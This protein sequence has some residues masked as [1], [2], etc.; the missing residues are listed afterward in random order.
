M[1]IKIKGYDVIIDDDVAPM[2]LPHKWHIRSKS[3]NGKP[4]FATKIKIGHRKYRD[5]QLHR[6]IMGEPDGIVDH[7]SRNTLDNRR[8]NLRICTVI[9]NNRNSEHKTGVTG[10]PNVVFDKKCRSKPYRTGIRIREKWVWRYAADNPFDAFLAY[11]KKA[12]EL[13]GEFY[14]EAQG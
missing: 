6:L 5:V 10:F 14:R 7:R 13:F 3:C 9:E 2:I 1:T 11:E 8:Q 4:Y 12:K